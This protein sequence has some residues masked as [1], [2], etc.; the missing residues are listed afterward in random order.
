MEFI[1]T[2]YGDLTPDQIAVVVRKLL[3][4]RHR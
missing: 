2:F 4:E 1:F 3:A